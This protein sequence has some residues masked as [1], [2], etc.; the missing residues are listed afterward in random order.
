[1]III[2][3]N[4]SDNII[5]GS[6]CFKIGLV[7]DFIIG[8]AMSIY[9][10]YI[11]PDKE[12]Q[13]IVIPI[14]SAVYGGLITMVGVAWTIKKAD[15]D[16]KAEERKN[17]KPYL[18]IYQNNIKSFTKTIMIGNGVPKNTTQISNIG[19][20]LCIIKYITYDEKTEKV[21]NGYIAAGE[22]VVVC[23][24]FEHKK[25][26]SVIASD[27]LG[28]EYEFEFTYQKNGP[29]IESIGLPKIIKA[30]KTEE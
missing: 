11:I 17:A 19:L 8:V 26:K 6:P 28:N 16:K 18:Q 15:D 3:Y 23:F 9:L 25:I 2:F 1:M 22:T 30:S 20:E 14:L 29:H 27:R 21:S 10:V 5:K 24:N 13:S 7:Q 12:L 4:L